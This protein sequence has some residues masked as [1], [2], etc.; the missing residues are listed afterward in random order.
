MYHLQETN[1][2]NII[3]KITNSE[4]ARVKI[5]LI[6]NRHSQLN[7]EAPRQKHPLIVPLCESWVMSTIN[8]L[9]KRIFNPCQGSQRQFYCLKKMWNAQIAYTCSHCIHFWPKGQFYTYIILYI[10]LN[11][12]NCW[13]F[14]I[15]KTLLR[16]TGSWLSLSAFPPV[17]WPFHQLTSH[18]TGKTQLTTSSVQEIF[19][20]K[21]V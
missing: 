11:K 10:F 5:N 21:C 12:I 2:L 4:W 19:D 15:K 7:T 18:P 9:S 13:G 16:I 6:K 1:S 20:K 17:V 14:H 8:M 3:C